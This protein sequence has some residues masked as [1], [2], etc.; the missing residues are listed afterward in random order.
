VKKP[1]DHILTRFDDDLKGLR[2]LTLTMGAS[3]AA[4]VGKAAAALRHGDGGLARQILHQ[5]KRI[6]E[7]D[8][9]GQE[10]ALRILATHNPVARDLRLVLCLARSIS[11]LERVANQ[12]KKVA[13]IAQRRYTDAPYSLGLSIFA[14]VSDLADAALSM[15]GDTLRALAEDDI[16]LAV[17]V[18]Q[19]DGR[20]NQ[21]FEG[22]MR[23]LSTFLLEDA[24]N[25][26]WVMDAIFALKAMERVGDGA[27]NVAKQLIFAVKGVDVRYIKAEHLAE[28][29]LDAK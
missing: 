7:R 8:M 6:Y 16:D 1:G 2:Q 10:E 9:Q 5:V 22:A 14:D 12:A 4:L 24:R 15:L 29:Y 13:L 11:E 3:V 23:R 25:I 28:G 17:A 20:L 21:L 26:G 18:V 27:T 19:R